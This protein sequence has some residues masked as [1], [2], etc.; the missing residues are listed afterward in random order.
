MNLFDLMVVF[1][2]V[3]HGAMGVR[4]G[5]VK[6]LVNLT[7][8]FLTVVL[9]SL[10]AGEITGIAKTVPVVPD[11]V[12]VPLAFVLLLIAGIIL[13]K[14]GGA[15]LSGVIHVTPL[16]FVDNGLGTA[17]GIL[18]ALLVAAIIAYPLSLAPGNGFFGGQFVSSQFAPGLARL[19]RG[20]IPFATRAAK[21]V[22]EK[23][24]SHRAPVTGAPETEKNEPVR[25]TP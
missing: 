16:G 8:L 22:S 5:L 1:L 23:I 12:A 21:V 19:A 15:L 17:L 10:F 18:K 9:L 24:E 13:S 11:A 3:L 20:I 7:G 14:V 2:V 4:E 6:G 25:Q